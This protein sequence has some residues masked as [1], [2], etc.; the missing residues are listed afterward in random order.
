MWLQ[1]GRKKGREWGDAFAGI[2]HRAIKDIARTTNEK[3]RSGLFQEVLEGGT[4]RCYM[5]A[6]CC[7]VTQTATSDSQGGTIL[8]PAVRQISQPL[9]FGQCGSPRWFPSEP[10]GAAPPSRYHCLASGI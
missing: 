2:I 4:R 1:E 10:L 3:V 7:T 6:V 8:A 5:Q 9:G